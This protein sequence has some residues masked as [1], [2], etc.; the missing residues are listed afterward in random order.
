MNVK[1]ER[2]TIY[3]NETC[4]GRGGKAQLEYSE[5]VAAQITQAEQAAG[6]VQ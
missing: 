1:R 5:G 4:L 3:I 2:G 6:S